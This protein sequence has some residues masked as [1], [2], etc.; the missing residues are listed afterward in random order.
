MLAMMVLLPGLAGA[1]TTTYAYNN[2]SVAY[3]GCFSDNAGTYGRTGRLFSGAGCEV[4][5][6]ATGQ[7]ISFTYAATGSYS[8]AITVTIANTDGSSP[9]AVT[10]TT[11]ST[12]A[13]LVGTS[14][15]Q[16]VGPFTLNS[17]ADATKL[18]TFKQTYANSGN[19][20]LDETGTNAISVTGTAPALAYPTT[21]FGPIT[22]LSAAIPAGYVQADGGWSIGA[23][24]NG[25]IGVYQSIGTQNT[26]PTDCGIRFV[27]T[28]STIKVWCYFAN[29]TRFVLRTDNVRGTTVLQAA[30]APYKW[31]WVTLTTT[32]D[33][34]A[35]HEYIIQWTKPTSVT[36]YVF[37]IQTFGGTGI[38]TTPIQARETW[39]W[40][41]D[42]ITAVSNASVSPPEAWQGFA[43]KVCS[44]Y[45]VGC[46]N[47]GIGSTTVKKFSSGATQV[48]TQAA[49]N[50]S[51]I[52]DITGI[53]PYPTRV[54]IVY[55]TNDMH[56]AGGVEGIPEF[57]QSYQNMMTQLM[58]GLPSSTKFVCVGILP[59]TG[60]TQATTQQWNAGIKTA[61]LNACAATGNSNVMYMDMNQG[62]LEIP[63]NAALGSPDYADLQLHLNDAGY[64]KFASVFEQLLASQTFSFPIRARRPAGRPRSVETN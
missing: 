2:A 58:L 49:E 39:A 24:V 4:D 8:N 31:G 33:A 1:V 63:N 41:G 55:G 3:S 54:I 44:F 15:W 5:F 62:Q 11:A 25:H 21:Q 32:A 45:R 59:C 17:G 6:Y 52:L 18:V 20:Y 37:Q 43:D 48:T 23:N 47:R 14:A 53:R 42:S 19:F 12:P 51:R 60:F 7:S 34:T 13:V 57:I 16:T 22:N 27:A 50:P 10:L 64:T 38:F 9:V 26:A 28:A 56:Q 40:Y 61:I 36:P 29:A 46:A 30:D 35:P